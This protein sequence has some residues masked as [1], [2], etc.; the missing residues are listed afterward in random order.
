MVEER[1]ATGRTTSRGLIS[2]SGRT[3]KPRSRVGHSDSVGTENLVLAE[4]Y[5]DKRGFKRLEKG[6]K[7]QNRQLSSAS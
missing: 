4:F 7:W 3:T 6:A 1:E 2:Y 5:R